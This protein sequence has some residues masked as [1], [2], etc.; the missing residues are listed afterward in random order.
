MSFVIANLQYVEEVYWRYL[1]N[2]C[3]ALNNLVH[4]LWL[5]PSFLFVHCSGKL[6]VRAAKIRY[7]RKLQKTFLSAVNPQNTQRAR[8]SIQSSE[9]GPHTPSQ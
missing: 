8:L 9:L 1:E 6:Y 5:N 2:F 4:F 7:E 3:V